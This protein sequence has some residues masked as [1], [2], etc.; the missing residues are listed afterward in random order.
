M[1]LLSRPGGSLGKLAGC[2]SKCLCLEAGHGSPARCPS[3]YMH[4]IRGPRPCR[5]VESTL[6]KDPCLFG[7]LFAWGMEQSGYAATCASNSL[8][9]G[10]LGPIAVCTKG[11]AY[12]HPEAAFLGWPVSDCCRSAASC[13]HLIPSC[14]CALKSYS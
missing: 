10:W 8:S 11:G 2:L 3:K 9:C 13:G 7:G 4:L 1:G 5:T 12:G 14:A 6:R